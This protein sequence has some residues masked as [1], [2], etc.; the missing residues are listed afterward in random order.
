MGARDTSK[1]ETPPVDRL[2]IQTEVYPFSTDL[3]KEAILK[4]MDRDG[5]VF[6]LHNRIESIYGIVTMLNSLLPDLRVAVGHGRLPEDKLERVML[7][8]MNHQYDV[9]VC[10]TI[11][12]SGI[13]IPN[14]NTLIVN[15]ADKLGL[16]QLYQIRGRIGRSNRQA[17][18]YLLTP[19]M[20][21]LT[22]VA[23]QRLAT[24]TEFTELGS[25]M[26]IALKDLEIRGAGNLLGAQ[27]SGY[28]NAV[29]F[30]MY[31]R[32][33][34]EA[35]TEIKGHGE[36]VTQPKDTLAEEVKVEFPGAAFIT[37][38]YIDDGDIRYQFYRKLAHSKTIEEVNRI[39]AELM[40]RFGVLP[41]ETRNLMGI[42]RIKL[43]SRLA[44]FSKV[45]VEKRLMTATLKL[46]SNPSESQSIIRGLVVNGATDRME[47]KM[48]SPISL[49]YH[50]TSE[51]T[52]REATIFLQKL[53]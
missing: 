53:T 4:E 39:E 32:L 16:A 25:G 22:P 46:P 1:I 28:I 42:V 45:V 5:Q 35:I 27:Q 11:I 7:D 31:T 44:H 50:F 8:F 40:D 34:E 36:P 20:L 18:A 6:F 30:D 47:F 12:E 52:L 29:G 43:L 49:I 33:L 48:T 13:D 19:P 37:N 23:R 17:Y 15:R 51:D 10:T 38:D 24:L 14:V 2:P 9:L 3:I 41:R 26:N 21:V